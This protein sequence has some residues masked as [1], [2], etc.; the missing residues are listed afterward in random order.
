MILKKSQLNTFITFLAQAI[1]I[2]FFVLEVNKSRVLLRE[3]NKVMMRRLR[4]P[5]LFNLRRNYFGNRI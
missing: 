5:S 2:G 4:M 3:K 1:L